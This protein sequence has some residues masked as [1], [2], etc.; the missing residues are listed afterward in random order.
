MSCSGMGSLRVIE[1]ACGRGRAVQLSEDW[2]RVQFFN[3]E[4]EQGAESAEMIVITRNGK[5]TVYT[6]WRAWL[7][8]AAALVVAWLVLVR[9]AFLW[10]GAAITVGVTMLLAVPALAVVAL[11]GSMMRR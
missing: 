3:P 2:K 8:G 4:I 5:A 6:G 10:V 1:I 11:I 9:L 7:I